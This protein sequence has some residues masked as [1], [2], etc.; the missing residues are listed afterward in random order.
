MK[1]ETITFK[2]FTSYEKLKMVDIEDYI[3]DYDRVNE[4]TVHENDDP[5]GGYGGGLYV[6]GAR[7][8]VKK[9]LKNFEEMVFRDSISKKNARNTPLSGEQIHII[10]TLIYNR[11][12][13]NVKEKKGRT[14]LIIY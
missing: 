11:V 2:D 14:R 7:S 5:K 9:Y 10:N 6:M 4:L 13:I 8:T 3:I 12:I 1:I